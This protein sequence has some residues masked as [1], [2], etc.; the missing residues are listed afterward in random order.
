VPPGGPPPAATWGYFNFSPKNLKTT[1]KKATH[2]LLPEV[3]FPT[4]YPQLPIK[5]SCKEYKGKRP[6]FNQCGELGWTGL[7]QPMV[8][9][10]MQP[11]MT[12]GDGDTP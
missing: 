4:F 7:W 3:T 5:Y 8:K 10:P 11:T 12:R 2:H 6:A 9:H 1:F